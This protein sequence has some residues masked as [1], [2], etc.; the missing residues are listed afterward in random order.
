MDCAPSGKRVSCWPALRIINE[1]LP[2]DARILLVAEARC[3]LM[4]RD[5]LVED[6]YQKPL[7][8]EL[9]ENEESPQ[10]V[11][12]RLAHLSKDCR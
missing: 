6:A 1:Q 9:S 7:I 10:A 2:A 5:V 11:A 3:F 12:K 8:A 4:D